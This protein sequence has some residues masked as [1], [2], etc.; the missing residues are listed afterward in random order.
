MSYWWVNL[1]KTYKYEVKG[2]MWSPQRT[3]VGRSQA[4]DNML[5][6]KPGD[7]IFAFHDTRIKAI[8]IATASALP[9]PKPDFGQEGV[10]WDSEGWLVEVQFTELV[11]PVRIRE[12]MDLVGP[13]LPKKYSPVRANGHG[14]EAYLFAV[15]EEMAAVVS[16]L[17][18]I[19]LEELVNQPV[20]LVA[21]ETYFDSVEASLRMRMEISETEKI[22]LVKSRRGQGLFKA[23]VLIVESACRVTGVTQVSMLRASHVKPWSKSDDREKIDGFN[24][25]LLAPHVDHLFDKGYIT[26]ESK[27]EMV[28]S[29]NLNTE[30]LDRWS[31]PQVLNVGSFSSEQTEYL[32]Y[33]QDSVFQAS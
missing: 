19:Q 11:K 5:L 32:N 29:P 10:H 20:K 6:I 28:L 30:I 22:Q 8:G 9:C 15:P 23:N 12:H 1:G 31:I 26:F 18:D 3:A 17:L 7:V 24:G 21:D 13:T 33:H 14:N 4:Y 27:G 2:F 16:I 25:L